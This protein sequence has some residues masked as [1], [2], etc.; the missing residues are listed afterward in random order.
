MASPWSITDAQVGVPDEHQHQ[1]EQEQAGAYEGT[2]NH[3]ALPVNRGRAWRL[4]VRRGNGVVL[5][6]IAFALIVFGITPF[7]TT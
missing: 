5:P 1:P 2:A 7:S 6:A 4:M 3:V